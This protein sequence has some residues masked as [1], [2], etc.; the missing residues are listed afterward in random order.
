ME[1][2]PIRSRAIRPRDRKRHALHL[3]RLIAIA[4]FALAGWIALA[5]LTDSAFASDIPDA[6]QKTA[7][8]TDRRPDTAPAQPRPAGI[9]PARP[10]PAAPAVPTWTA[11]I[12]SADGPSVFD[13]APRGIGDRPIRDAGAWG[14]ELPERVHERVQEVRDRPVKFLQARRHKVFDRKDRVVGHVRGLADAAGIPR[15]RVGDLRS[16]TPLVGGLVREIAGT[17]PV[18]GEDSPAEDSQHQQQS[19]ADADDDGRAGGEAADGASPAPGPQ[20]SS[21]SDAQD[22][23]SGH[24]AGCQGDQRAPGPVAPSGQD[25]PRGSGGHLFAPIADL[26]YGLSTAAPAAVEVNTFHRTALTDVSAPG[27][28]SVV[29][30]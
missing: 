15:V 21:A 23:A 12:G 16:E 22:E 4:G 3:V 14:R 18:P 20:A 25:S 26:R 29:P 11:E 24:C 30:D 8:H 10:R 9:A 13:G 17:Q 19:P 6:S 2:A 5:A 1:P 28:P 7:S 27:G